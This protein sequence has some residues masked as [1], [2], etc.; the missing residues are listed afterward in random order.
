MLID[1]HCHL[2]IQYYPD[3]CDAALDRARADGVSGFMAIGVDEN[4]TAAK[5]AIAVAGRRPDVWA[6]IGLHP[7]DAKCLTPEM[8]AELSLLAK[9]PRVVAFGEIGLDYHYMHSPK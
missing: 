7:H 3:G 5:N 6:S 4:L 1:S 8:E 2:D 9:S